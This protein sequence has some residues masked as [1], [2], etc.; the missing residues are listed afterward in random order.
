MVSDIWAEKKVKPASVSRRDEM[1][2][3]VAHDHAS[4]FP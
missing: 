1:V 3:S 4:S 2:E